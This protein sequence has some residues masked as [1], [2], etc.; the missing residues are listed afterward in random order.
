MLD[1]LIL[2]AK[3]IDGTGKPAYK[4]CIGIK[5]GKIVAANGTEE[6]KKTI[7]AKNCVVSPGFIDPHSHCD[8]S[9]GQ[10]ELNIV[11]TNQGITTELTGNCGA[12]AAPINPEYIGYVKDLL[13]VATLKYS[14]DMPNWTSF[15][16]YLEFADSC[17][18][19][20]N[21][22]F[23]VGHNALRIAVMGM[24]NRP[25]TAKGRYPGKVIRHNI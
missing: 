25:A 17:E 13:S 16:R 4:G 20:T 15:E 6:S 18:K 2:N 24:E 21:V 8:H 23:M 14:D 5:N 19:T 22:R 7:D 11:K 10:S 3:I 12:S 1:C 9:L